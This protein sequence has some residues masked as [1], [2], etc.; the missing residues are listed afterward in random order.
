MS[1]MCTKKAVVALELRL[2]D[3]TKIRFDKINTLTFSLHAQPGQLRQ[4]EISATYGRR[5]DL[6]PLPKAIQRRLK[7]L[8]GKRR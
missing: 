7:R 5:L 1:L 8:R 3:G 4:V 2:R 6:D